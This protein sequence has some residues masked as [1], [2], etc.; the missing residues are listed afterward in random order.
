MDLVMRQDS[1]PVPVDTTAS[2]PWRIKAK[3]VTLRDITYRMKMMPIIDSLGAQVKTAQ[4]S[5]GLVDLMTQRIH[6]A[7]LSVD[8]VTAAVGNAR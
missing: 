1:T 7:S 6:A 8:S 4:L 5:D 2:T 3:M